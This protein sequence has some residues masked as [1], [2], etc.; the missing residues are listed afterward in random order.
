MELKTQQ[1]NINELIDQIR[2]TENS[3]MSIRIKN[4]SFARCVLFLGLMAG[5]DPSIRVKD[6]AEFMKYSKQ[7]ALYVL[8]ELSNI[9]IIRN[10]GKAKG[11]G[12]YNRYAFNYGDQGKYIIFDYIEEAKK[13]LGLE[14]K[15]KFMKVNRRQKKQKGNLYI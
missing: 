15:P 9:G 2:P 5:K 8:D 12:N 1:Q 7:R 14:I 13:T 6:L 11:L 3:M 4:E 10:I